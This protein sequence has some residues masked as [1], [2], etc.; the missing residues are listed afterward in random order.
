MK[1]L[2]LKYSIEFFVI[3]FSISVSF[4]VENLRERNEKDALRV[5]IKNS[6][7]KELEKNIS[8]LETTRQD[9]ETW[10][11]H[12][13]YFLRHP[14]SLDNDLI[15]AFMKEYNYSPLNVYMTAYSPDLPNT[16]YNALVNDGSINLIYDSA[17]K[18][19]I[20]QLYNRSSSLVNA[21]VDDE[22]N[23][24]TR[25]ENY[26]VEKYPKIYLKDFWKKYYNLDL[27]SQAINVMKSDNTF[28]ATMMQKESFMTAK[29]RDF[30][31]YLIQRDSLINTLKESLEN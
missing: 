21:W 29:L 15:T 19:S 5:L 8:R 6:L 24:A 30:N 27:Y 31:L 23:V 25:A 18:L 14:D 11:K 22:K 17:L 28:K 4:F 20:E 2:I 9:L 10:N 12:M 26:F 16:T 13:Y 1:K 7:L 3:V